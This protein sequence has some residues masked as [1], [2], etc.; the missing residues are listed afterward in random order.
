MKK[1]KETF[2]MYEGEIKNMNV[3]IQDLQ[4]LKKDL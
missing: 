3:R 4:K 1:S 2:K